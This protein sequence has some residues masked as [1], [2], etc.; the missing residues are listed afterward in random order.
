MVVVPPIASP[1]PSPDQGT[2]ENYFAGPS[3]RLSPDGKRLIAWAW[4]DSYDPNGATRQTAQ[5]GWLIDLGGGAD[6]GIRRLADAAWA[7]A[8]DAPSDVLLGHL[9]GGGRAR[10]D[11]LARLRRHDDHHAHLAR[12][13]RRRAPTCRA[14]RPGELMAG[15]PRARPRRPASLH[16]ATGRTHPPPGRPGQRHD[17]RAQGRP[18]R[19]G[20]RTVRNRRKRARFRSR[21]GLGRPLTRTCTPYYA[22]QFVAEPG[23]TRLFALGV[24]ATDTRHHPAAPASGC[25]MRLGRPSSAAGRHSR[26][27][28]ASASRPIGGGCSRQARRESMRRQADGLGDVDH[29]LRPLRRT[30][31]A[32]A[33]P[34][35]ELTRRCFK[36]RRSLALSGPSGAATRPGSSAILRTRCN[37][38]VV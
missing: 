20:G 38:P 22:P 21:A 27:T 36:S 32:A 4:V 3:I 24:L 14:L 16:L 35:R 2:A 9:D 8:R 18:S 23:S 13:G 17:R 12:P 31:G 34:S 30:S 15:G 19:N 10:R 7:G 5:Q 11:L 25:S 37:G 26:P 28:G 29:R 6:E 33:R 1:T